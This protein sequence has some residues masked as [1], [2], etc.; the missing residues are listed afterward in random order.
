[1]LHLR[2]VLLVQ[3]PLVLLLGLLVRLRAHGS[4]DPLIQLVE[5][6]AL[7]VQDEGVPDV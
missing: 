7:P 4:A 1:V 2:G 3:L 6:L 5:L